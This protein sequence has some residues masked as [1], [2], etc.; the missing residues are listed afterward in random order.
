MQRGYEAVVH[1][2]VEK[3]SLYNA[4][5][6]ASVRPADSEGV[7]SLHAVPSHTHRRRRLLLAE[8]NPVLQP[9]DVRPDQGW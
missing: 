9:P 1:V 7:V 6:Y 2:P 3:T 4:I 5:H 8:D